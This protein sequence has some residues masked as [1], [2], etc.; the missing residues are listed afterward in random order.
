MQF[1]ALQHYME[2]GG[3]VLMMLGEGGE[4]RFDTNINYLL[5]QYGMCINTGARRNEQKPM[6]V[7]TATPTIAHL[8]VILILYPHPL[9]SSSAAD[10]VVRSAYHK[11]HHPKECLVSNGVLNRWDGEV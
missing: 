10:A 5:E 11:Y 6:G 3:S 7:C 4:S 8:P 9:S 1:K 2:T